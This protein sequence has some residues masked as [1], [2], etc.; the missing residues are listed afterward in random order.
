MCC[1]ARA[2]WAA[3]GLSQLPRLCL[4]RISTFS[5]HGLY[6]GSTLSRPFIRAST[7]RFTSP[8]DEVTLAH[9][10]KRC[11]HSAHFWPHP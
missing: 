1:G 10:M 5:S 9:S 3:V 7:G 2:K 6:G 11:S 4:L 8:Q